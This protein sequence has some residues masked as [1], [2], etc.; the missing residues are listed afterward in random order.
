MKDLAERFKMFKNANP[1]VGDVVILAMASNKRKNTKRELQK[2]FTMFV[3]EDQFLKREK[4][5]II[6]WLFDITQK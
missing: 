4:E 1:D 6:D 2:A 3:T 5:E